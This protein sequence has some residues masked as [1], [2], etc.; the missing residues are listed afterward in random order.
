MKIRHSMTPRHPILNIRDILAFLHRHWRF[1]THIGISS[2]TSASL[3]HWPFYI[4]IGVC[5]YSDLWHLHYQGLQCRLLC[6]HLHVYFYTLAF[7]LIHWHFPSYIG[8]SSYTL[9]FLLIDSPFYIYLGVCWYLHLWHLHYQGHQCHMLCKIGISILTHWYFY[10]YIGIF[11][12]SQLWHLHYQWHQCR[13]LCKRWHLHLYI[14]IC[15]YTLAF[16]LSGIPV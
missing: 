15:T 14:G 1:F 4:K 10:I 5:C 9:A 12:C 7:V 3:V 6:K 16:P 2:Y 11:C 8:I 13:L